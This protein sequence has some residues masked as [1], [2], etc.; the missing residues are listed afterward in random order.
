VVHGLPAED[1]GT[2]DLPL[3]ADWPN[4]PR[5][6][7]DRE[8]GKPSQTAW[9]VIARD[10]ASRRTRLALEPLTGRSHQLRVHLAAIG[11]PILGDIL[12]GRPDA[13]YLDLVRGARDARREEGAPARQLLHCARLTFP[14][15]AGGAPTTVEAPLPADLVRALS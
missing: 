3:A 2:I 8:R 4:R 12:Y 7:V 9:R 1:A 6:Q 14:A 10:E 15:P 11:H 5:Q 13:D